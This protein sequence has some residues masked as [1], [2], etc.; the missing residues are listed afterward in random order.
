VPAEVYEPGTLEHPAIPGLMLALEARLYGAALEYADGGGEIH[1]ETADEK[2]FRVL[3]RQ[4]QRPTAT[5]TADSFTTM[6][7]S[8]FHSEA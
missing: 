8:L 3:W 1:I 4:P 6:D 5:R 7:T 2:R